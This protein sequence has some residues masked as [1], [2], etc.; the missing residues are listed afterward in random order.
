MYCVQNGCPKGNLAY[1]QKITF[2]KA[3]LML[4]FFKQ[5]IF[6]FHFRS[7]D[8][9]T[10]KKVLLPKGFLFPGS[11]VHLASHPID[12]DV[13][14]TKQ[15]FTGNIRC[16]KGLNRGSQIPFALAAH[17]KSWSSI[18]TSRPLKAITSHLEGIKCKGRFIQT[19]EN[20]TSPVKCEFWQMF[21][22]L[23]F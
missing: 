6:L 8:I 11:M 4:L 23:K 16:K 22:I 12:L 9:F 2:S 7:R 5:L 3:E 1:K 15:L 21:G 14:Y 18:R 13:S 17:L 20:Q 19:G 10:R